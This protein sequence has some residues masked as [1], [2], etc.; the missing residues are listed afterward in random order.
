MV[1]QIKANADLT[2]RMLRPLS[3]I[4]FGYTPE[5]VQW[6]EG[7]IERLRQSGEFTTETVRNKMVSV[8]G[9]FLGECIIR[10]YGGVWAQNNGV[11][12]VAFDGNNSAFPFAKVSKQ[13]DNGLE[14]GIGS[15]FSVIPELFSSHV[16]LLPPTRKPW[17]KFWK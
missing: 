1:N 3:R 6:L 5:S 12:C 4:N 2:I 13:I 15:F 8:F 17:W 9:S 11:W 16:H 7:Y 10:R 14:D